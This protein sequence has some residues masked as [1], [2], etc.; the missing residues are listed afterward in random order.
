MLRDRRLLLAI[1]LMFG[2]LVAGVL[3]VISFA[4]QAAAPSPV[5]PSVART[6]P[7]PS[8]EKPPIQAVAEYKVAA[9]APKYI[10]IPV[11]G[12]GRTRVNGLGIQKDNR[13]SAPA[14][15]HDA[16]WYQ[17]SAKPG[18]PGAMFVYGHV[19]SPTANGV[20]HELKRLKPG[21]QITITR[22]D[23]TKY[24]YKVDASKTYPYNE[25]DMQAVLSPMKAGDQALNLMTCAGKV[26]RG[27]NEYD[28]R[29][30]VFTSLIKT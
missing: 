27:S 13:I 21:D 8:S 22:G 20:F 5:A 2:G 14:N 23:D 16:G 11:L 7:P 19:S 29:L 6:T 3:A 10:E 24:T 25:V 15:I 12:V 30:V 18:Q 4:D 28:Q 1:L 26:M 17:G 9:D